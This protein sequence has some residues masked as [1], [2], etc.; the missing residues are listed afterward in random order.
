MSL[1]AT[2]NASVDREVKK[3]QVALKGFFRIADEWQC[4]TQEKIALLGG[5]SRSTLHKWGKLPQIRLQRDTMERI[6]LI[7][8]IYK[9]LQ[10]L[11]PTHERA[12]R[13]IRL[14][15]AEPPFGGKSAIEFMAQ[16]SMRH[17][18]LARRYFDA[19]RG[20]A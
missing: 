15:T 20:W 6:S 19:R 1:A 11:Y 14:Q 16:G 7:M 10:V 9:A 13:R 12:N 3:G 5:V 8:G 17:L 2:D 4:S 18:M